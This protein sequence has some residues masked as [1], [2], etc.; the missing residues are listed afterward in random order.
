MDMVKINVVFLSVYSVHRDEDGGND[1]LKEA[2]HA[3]GPD[4]I[5]K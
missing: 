4:F 3:L 1:L 2:I 5:F